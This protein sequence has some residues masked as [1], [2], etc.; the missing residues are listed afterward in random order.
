MSTEEVITMEN[1]ILE[2]AKQVFV[3]KGYEATKMG[4]VAAEAGIGRTALHYY[5]RTK[6]MLSRCDFRPVD[7]CLASEPG[8]I[9]EENTSFL[10]KLPKIIDQYVRT[11][12][13]NPLFPVFVINELQRDPEH[14]YHSILKN[15]HG[16]NQSSECVNRWRMRWREVY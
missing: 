1:R 9:M 8:A 16:L 12:Q 6:E 11:L 2:A 15:P 7:R 4:D 14:I 3:R 10:E 13:R 5:Y